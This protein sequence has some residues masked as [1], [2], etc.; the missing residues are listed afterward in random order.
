VFA[1]GSPVGGVL[2]GDVRSVWGI[3]EKC[4]LEVGDLGG[5]VGN[6]ENLNDIDPRWCFW[7]GKVRDPLVSRL[8]QAS[9]LFWREIVGG[10]ERMIR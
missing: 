5:S 8:A 1:W 9:F 10:A 6:D 3:E 4:V 7:V 2:S